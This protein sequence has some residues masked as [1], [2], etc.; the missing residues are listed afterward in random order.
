VKL[1]INAAA[2]DDMLR[3][4]DWYEKQ[5]L[6]DVADRYNL[7]VRASIGAAL[8]RPKAGAP[9]RVRNPK[10]AGLR[11]WTV[12]G[13]HEFHVYYVIQADVFAVVRVLHDKRDVSVILNKQP[14]D[15]PELD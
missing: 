4:Y 10:L 8:K 1:I 15:D 13:F 11:S 7:A 3:Q 9:K 14:L 6:L 12:E 2:E 5:G